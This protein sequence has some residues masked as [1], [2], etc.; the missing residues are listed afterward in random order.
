MLHIVFSICNYKDLECLLHVGLYFL[1]ICNRMLLIVLCLLST[2]FFHQWWDVFSQCFLIYLL[3]TLL[4]L[5][6]LSV[7]TIAVVNHQYDKKQ[8]TEDKISLAY[9]SMSQSINHV[10]TQRYKLKAGTEAET[11][12]EQWLLACSTWLP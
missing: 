8:V 1:L 4:S 5:F 12:H 6:C 3:I 11:M 7:A 9:I 2:V 10:E